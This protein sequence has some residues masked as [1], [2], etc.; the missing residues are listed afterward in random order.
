MTTPEDHEAGDPQLRRVLLDA[1]PDLLAPEDRIGQVAGRVKKRRVQRLVAAGASAAA[2]VLVMLGAAALFAP[3][4]QPVSPGASTPA[5][6]VPPMTNTPTPVT[7]SR[8][9][10]T[11]GPTAAKPP[12]VSY[13]AA[14]IPSGSTGS[15]QLRV[16]RTGAMPSAGPGAF[17][18]VCQY[19]HMAPE[20][21]VRYPGQASASPLMV[22]AGN[23]GT[24]SQST[25]SSLVGA[26]NGTCWG[27]VADRSAYWTAAL[28]DTSTGTPVA[29]T[30]FSIRYS[31]NSSRPDRVQTMPAGLRL[32]STQ[33]SW[34]CWDG[35]LTT[36]ERPPTCPAGAQLVLNLWFPRCW[37]GTDLDS[38]DHFSHMAYPVGPNCPADHPV[39][40]PQLEYHVLYRA[41]ATST[42]RL[43]NDTSAEGAPISGYAG[44]FEGWVPEIRQTWT[45]NCVRKSV[46]CE[47]HLIGDGRIIEGDG[48]I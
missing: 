9:A 21:P 25:A 42:W 37:N 10:N 48:D 41:P 43:S 46:N 24:R 7:T 40:I 20:D 30:E 28:I 45:D 16:T 38:A 31:A 15:A 8:P 2:L 6:T 29:P 1:V 12:G 32:L 11:G 23:T 17:R 27:G 44:Y 22:Y 13:L 18:Q 5:T 47:G 19:S 35:T 3:A 39:M 14:R 26:G 4:E 36:Y 33:A 34:G